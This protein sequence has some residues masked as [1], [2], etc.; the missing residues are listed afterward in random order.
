M[1]S[2]NVRGLI[3]SVSTSIAIAGALAVAAIGAAGAGPAGAATLP[4]GPVLENSFVS[5]VG[6]VK[7]GDKYPF[8]LRAKNYGATPL[9]NAVV[10]LTAPDSTTLTD[11]D[12]AGGAVD[13]TGNTLTWNAG[14][15][16][17][18]TGTNPGLATQI[19]EAKADGFAEDPQIVWKDLSTD[20]SLTYTGA[21]APLT[22]RSHGPKVI[23]PSGGYETA[24]YGDRPFPVVPVDFFDRKHDA[25]H[26]SSLLDTKINDPANP[27]STFNLYQEMSYG[28]LFPQGTV[29][30]SGVSTAPW[31]YSPGYS[32][33]TIN[34][35]TV[36]T[37]H[38]VTNAQLP[39]DVYQTL[40]PNRI[41]DGWY[42]LP[43]TTDYYGDDGNGSALIGAETGQGALQ[44]IDSGCGPTGKSVYDAAQIADPDIDYNDY[45]TDKDGVVD[46]FMMI[47]PGIGGNGDSQVNGVPPYDN[48]W[49]HSSDLR[50][51][52]ID[53]DTGLAGYI[54]DDRRTDLEGHP[55]WY[56][57][58]TFTQTTTQDTGDALKAYV[59]VGPY[60]VNPESAIDKAS[61]ISHEYGHSLGLPDYYTNG[62]RTTY[63]SWMLMAEDHSQNMDIIGKKELGWV[64]PRALEANQTVNVPNWQDTKLDTH[65]IDW[66]QPDGTP[67]T[68][69]GSGVH[70]GLGFEAALPGRRIIDPALVPS[71]DRLWHSGFGNDFGCVPT[72][73]HNLD[74]ALPQLANV[75]AGT[76]VTMSFKT[77]FDIEWDFDYGFVLAT[78]DNG[79]NYTSLASDSG[80]T[81]ATANP[82]GAGCQQKF[83]NGLT[84]TNAS[85]DAG[86]APLDRIQGNYADPSFSDDSYDLSDYAGKATTIR[87]SY[88]T[89]GALTRPGWFIDDLVVKAGDQVIY[90]SDMEDEND[91][92]LVNGGCGDNGLRTGLL[93][94][95][96]WAHVTADEAST[97]EHGYLLEMRDRSGFDA[98]G[99]GEDDRGTGPTFDP[100]L[101]LT[102]TDEAHGYGNN[103]QQPEESPS[104]SP[105]DSQ[106][107]EGEIAP[108]LDDAAY[109]AAQNDSSFSDAPPGHVDNY[110]VDAD[111]TPWTLAFNCLSFNVTRM[112]GNEVGPAAVPPYDLN[113]DVS[114]TTGPGC[115]PFPFGA[116][117]V[118]EGAG[119]A[120]G[121]A[122]NPDNAKPTA[123]AQA[124]ATKVQVGE[125]VAFDGSA[126][127]DD[128][129]APE[130]LGYRWDFGD[131][132]RDSGRQTTHAF[133]AIGSYRVELT[134]KDSAGEAD[135]DSVRVEVVKSKTVSCKKVAATIVGTPGD[136]TLRGTGKRDV[137]VGLGGEDRLYGRGGND[138]ICGKG[139][140]DKKLSGGPKNDKVLG[141]G[142]NDKAGGG[143]GRD[144][145]NGGTGRDSLSG[146]RGRD[147][148]KGGPGRDKCKGDN[149]VDRVGSCER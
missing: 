6:W 107:Q 61:V 108:D 64:V 111:G 86:T 77:Y 140:N 15:V 130:D 118:G 79:R 66:E 74:L 24:R 30:S 146:G 63:G 21:G 89:D 98:D 3:V 127:F 50:G 44:A 112:A 75:P 113:G 54:S 85:Y 148:V 100:G 41:D 9:V 18:I 137:I 7:P 36:N 101:L 119:A 8:T 45:D 2:K 11:P 19:V 82:N 78:T 60:N 69:Q 20:A 138:V 110:V 5:S 43:G 37:C 39:G 65:R 26:Q 116:R 114:F 88:T 71:G 47:F 134:V 84:G 125:A 92:A 62:S 95:A 106:P 53:P 123:I 52:Y 68:L 104:Q 91:P 72:G 14:T 145:V 38:G 22:A 35:Q 1:G 76:P 109:T 96:G 97:A 46:F 4:T 90:Q 17:A 42:Q 141:G 147:R 129:D 83:G 33:T 128:L 115:A 132:E 94:T 144:K 27:G 56:T 67:Y 28:Q 70:N 133:S 124:K 80:Y 103:G 49:P 73:G 16:P 10:T 40:S 99:H 59:A 143:P 117:F 136:D 142:G 31:T 122:G 131:G 121:S 81:T 57:D 32:F 126:S 48:I 135:T 29:P 23:P 58:D 93:C 55:L 51:S 105:L 13:V 12:G 102:Y 139:G 34:P 120:G 87:F 149:T 25:A